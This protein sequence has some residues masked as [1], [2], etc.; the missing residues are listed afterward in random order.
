MRQ[1]LCALRQGLNDR[2]GEIN[3]KRP[4]MGAFDNRGSLHPSDCGGNRPEST[5]LYPFYMVISLTQAPRLPYAIRQ[6]ANETKCAMI[7]VATNGAFDQQAESDNH[8][9]ID[10]Y[11]T[12]T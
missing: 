12:R 5:V 3:T 4:Q 11:A 1:M 8:A 6:L 9:Q 10:D 2:I 7:E